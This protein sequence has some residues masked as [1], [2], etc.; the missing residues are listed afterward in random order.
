MT[1]EQT[2]KYRQYLR[3]LISYNDYKQSGEIADL[4][5]SEQY[6]EKRKKVKE[7]EQQK[8]RKL[9]EGL[10]CSMI[11]AYCRPFSGNDK[12]S[13][14][15]I[16]DLTKKVLDCL[17]KKE[18]FLHN[19]IIEERNKIIAHSDSEAWDITP[20]YILIEETNNKILF[21]CHKDV[22]APLLPQYVKMISEMS[23]KLMEEIFSRRMVLENELTDFFPIQSVSIKNNKK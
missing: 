3:L 1:P 13:K 17:T 7:E 4:I 9:W 8:I 18:K 2:N 11:I 21:P 16:P 10:N 23:S 20:Q 6:Y 14:N 22:R 12:K 5:L 19:E 15:K